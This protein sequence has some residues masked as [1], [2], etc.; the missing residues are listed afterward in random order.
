M[1]ALG[2]VVA[3]LRVRPGRFSLHSCDGAPEGELT[4][5]GRQPGG[6]RKSAV[7]I[8]RG[9]RRRAVLEL[10]RKLGVSVGC[11]FEQRPQELVNA[12]RAVAP[13]VGQQQAIDRLAQ[14]PNQ[15]QPS[16]AL[17]QLRNFLPERRPEAITVGPRGV[18]LQRSRPVR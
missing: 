6:F 5:S 4:L 1:Q 2:E 8:D 9:G 13:N 12:K 7:E 3:H 14:F 11:G 17:Q 18:G 16:A 15:L 10:A